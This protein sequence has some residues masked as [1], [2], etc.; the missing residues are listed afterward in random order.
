MISH[1]IVHWRKQIK[2]LWGETFTVCNKNHKALPFKDFP[3]YMHKHCRSNLLFLFYHLVLQVC[4]GVF[5]VIVHR[6]PCII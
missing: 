5:I 2:Q 1:C 6:G 4:F 3:L